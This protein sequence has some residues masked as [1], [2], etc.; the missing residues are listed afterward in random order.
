M[1]R[2]SESF[3]RNVRNSF[4]LVQDRSSVSMADK[5]CSGTDG[6]HVDRHNP[7]LWRA[8]LHSELHSEL[9]WITP[10]REEKQFLNPH[11]A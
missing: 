3:D 8:G 10:P 6:G 11:I 7:R 4:V 2:E 5:M 9:H 1:W